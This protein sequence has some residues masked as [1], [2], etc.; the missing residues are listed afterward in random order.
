MLARYDIT[1][2]GESYI[3]QPGSW[4]EG[5]VRREPESNQLGLESLKSRPDL[6]SFLQSSWIEGSM[7]QKPVV[8]NDPK[9]YFQSQNLAF[10]D[11]P[12]AV[13][14]GKAFQR[15]TFANDGISPVAAHNAYADGAVAVLIDGANAYFQ[16]WVASVDEFQSVSTNVTSRDPYVAAASGA[17]A[18][19]DDAYFLSDDGYLTIFNVN[20]GAIS[21]FDTTLTIYTGANLWADPDYVYVY[22]GDQVWRMDINGGY[23]F[24][25]GEGGTGPLAN[26]GLGP[27][28]MKDA[29][30]TAG[31]II[32]EWQQPRA[33]STAEGIF[34]MKNVYVNG[35]P[36]CKIYR[37]D[38]DAS[39]SF[40]LTP[41]K[42][43]DPGTIGITMAY[44]LGSLLISAVGNAATAMANAEHQKVTYYHVTGN[45]IGSLG[46]P[47]GGTNV[48][49][50]P[51][52]LLGAVD[53]IFYI[54]GNKRIWQYDARTG[55]MHPLRYESATYTNGGGGWWAMAPVKTSTDS[56]ILFQ[57]GTTYATVAGSVEQIV[58]ET[59]DSYNDNGESNYIT[60]NWFDFDL[61]MEEKSITEVYYDISD[62]RSG[63]TIAIQL[64]TDGGAFSTVATLTS[65]SDNTARVSI[66]PVTGFKFQY[67]LVFSDD[68]VTTAPEPTRLYALG[69]TASAGEMVK[70]MQFTI[71]GWESVN[72][73][74]NVQIPKDIYDN[75]VALRDNGSAVSVTH[76][77]V[78]DE[79][80]DSSTGTY[81]VQSVT[82]RKD[83][84]AEALI[85]VVLMEG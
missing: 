37:V 75:L 16:K 2:D 29:D 43:L 57:Y 34:Y 38:A 48:D 59:V 54:G 20:T 19:S 51:V 79:A 36:V 15:I 30:Y 44:H 67:K 45:S 80:D 8:R 42:T 39:G 11:R 13:Q 56:G 61:P 17:G 84:P 76:Y 28:I 85:E 33:I 6:R 69:F 63:S 62:V 68:S 52:W 7:W 82:I 81:K 47:L 60:S 3:I 23:A 1:I 18:S 83:D 10:A 70:V 9:T 24:V 66:T 12:G 78:S 46:S 77:M 71:N 14:E 58:Q 26:D 74:N 55:A 21:T 32:P 64:S 50:T 40:I 35:S 31:C 27:D 72:V 53:D 41:V 49:E 65:S 73:E 25:D 22:D 5:S 4:A